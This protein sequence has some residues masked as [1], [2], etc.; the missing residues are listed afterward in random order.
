MSNEEYEGDP[1]GLDTDLDAALLKSLEDW[2]APGTEL[3]EMSDEL[4]KSIEVENSPEKFEKRMKAQLSRS[5]RNAEKALAKQA[6]GQPPAHQYNGPPVRAGFDSEYVTIPDGKS[7][8]K[9]VVLVITLVIQCGGQQSRYMFDPQ[10]PDRAHRPTMSEFIGKGLRKAIKDGVVPSMPLSVTVFG[11]F[12]RADLVNFNDF[13]RRTDEFRGL[14]KT[15]VSGRSGHKL[16]V[17]ADVNGEEGLSDAASAADDRSEDARSEPG[18]AAA[19]PDPQAEADRGRLWS[20]VKHQITVRGNEG[21]RFSVRVRFVDTIKLTPGQRGLDYVGNM[22]NLPKLRL[23]EDLGVPRGPAPENPEMAKHGLPAVYGIE[24]MDLI[25]LDFRAAFDEYAF[26]DSEIALKYGLFMEDFAEKHLGL[27]RRAPS[28]LA[29]CASALIQQLSG[30][31]DALG[32]LV[33]RVNSTQ[34]YFHEATRTYKKRAI[35]D[36]VPGLDLYYD[37]ARKFY[38]GGRNECFYHGPTILA[39]WLDFDLPGAYTTALVALRRIDYENIR[40]ELDPDAYRIDVM[41]LAWVTFEFPAGTRFPCIPVRSADGALFFPL[42][43]EKEDRVFIASPEI[44]LARQMGA[45]VRI[46]QGIVA[47]WLSEE[48]IFERFT[49][50]VQQKR[51]DYPKA[52]HAALN[53]LWKEVGNSCYGLLAQGLREKRAYDPATRGSMPMAPSALSEPFLAAWTTSFIRAVLGEILAG[54]PQDGTVITATTDGLLTDVP[55]DRLRLDGPLC[56]YFADIRE[57]LFGDRTVLEIKHGAR[58]L[59]SVAVRTTFTARGAPAES[60]LGP[61]CAKGGTKSPWRPGAENR[62]MLLRYMRHKFGDTVT[63]EQFLSA[64]EQ[65]TREADLV[66]IKRTRRLKFLFDFKRRPVNGRMMPIGRKSERIAFDTA[67]WET[68]RQAEFARTRVEGWSRGRE[69]VF[70]DLADYR[71]WAE[72][73][74]AAAALDG[75]GVAAGRNDIRVGDENAWGVLRRVFLEAGRNG[76]LGISFPPRSAAA[77]ARAL[78]AAG[79]PTTKENVTYAKRSKVKVTP[80]CVALTDETLRLLRLILGLYPGF[81]YRLAFRPE[82][83]DRLDALLAAPPETPES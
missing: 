12:L 9:N 77:T 38:H 5:L 55:L 71:D 19:A 25:K 59:V 79:F 80:H 41:G 78:T 31:A 45:E 83:H 36:R 22:V 64:R 42:K 20:G 11:H 32:A 17:H 68:I 63:H 70:R 27:A 29:S 57:R 6:L 2:K 53:E 28:S 51:R 60:G 26:R 61:I 10:G 33:G 15:L 62:Y 54:V 39:A 3:D 44:F 65:L 14:G 48:R 69:R 74:A 47:P 23:H 37:F 35:Q 67:P 4:S 66:K 73:F 30:G 58:Q 49:R 56:S 43:G 34:T 1:D 75:A 40:Q 8:F 7:G 81:D 52:T 16:S 18:S 82:D 24:R 72:Y 76:L 13:W 21:E 46:V 50:L